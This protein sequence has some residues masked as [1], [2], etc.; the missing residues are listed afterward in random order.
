MFQRHLYRLEKYAGFLHSVSSV[1]QSC[2]TLCDPMD[3]S[4]T[5]FPGHQLLE[6]AQSHVHRGGDA[7]QFH[8]YLSVTIQSPLRWPQREG[9]SSPPAISPLTHRQK[10]NHEK[11]KQNLIL[12]FMSILYYG[13]TQLW[14]KEDW[15]QRKKTKSQT[16][17]DTQAGRWM[18]NNISKDRISAITF[19]SLA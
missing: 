18:K 1:A 19:S 15:G 4:T 5:G 10:R 14:E 12:K 11:F 9:T 17:N 8:P 7:Y 16:H 3:C 6:R 2:L 13:Y